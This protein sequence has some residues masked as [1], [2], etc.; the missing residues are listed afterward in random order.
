MTEIYFYHLERQPLDKVLVNLLERSLGRGWSCVVQ[1]GS[2]ERVDALDTLLWTYDEASFMPHGTAR[3]G[4]PRLQKVF[5]TTGEDNPNGAQIRFLVD[6][7]A[8]PDVSGYA[9]AVY[10]FDGRDADAVAAARQQ[11]TVA[12]AAGHGLSYWQQD[13]GGKWVD[14]G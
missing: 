6:G 8:I 10:M 5:L 9:R 11:W 1:A 2:D 3:D 14:K 4:H 13:D 12:K 7:A